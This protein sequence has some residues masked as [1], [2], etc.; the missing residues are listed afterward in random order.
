MINLLVLGR[1]HDRKKAAYIVVG[2]VLPDAA[3]LVF[4]LWNLVLGTSESTIWSVE[5]YRFGWQLIFDLLHSIPLALLGILICWKA[6]RPWLLVFFASILLHALGDLPL[7]QEDAHRH[8]FPL[9]DWRFF[10][11]VSDWNPAYYGN[12]VSLLEFLAVT[13][14][15]IFLYLKHPHL[16]FWLAGIGTTYLGYW[17]YVIIVWA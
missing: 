13:G 7:H 14:A 16:K 6:N 9:S 8:F 2:A 5:Y 11:P 12:W 4:Y 3:M 15:A 17:A 1:N 10:S